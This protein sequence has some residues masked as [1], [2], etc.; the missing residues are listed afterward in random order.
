MVLA[1]AVGSFFLFLLL[2]LGALAVTAALDKTIGKEKAL[3][4][5][6]AAIAA[7]VFFTGPTADTAGAGKSAS[8][9]DVEAPEVV[10]VDPFAHPP[11]NPA[12]KRN[13]F[14]KYSDTRPLPPITLEQ[15]PWIPLAFP[16]PPTVPGPA[17]AFRR[18]LRGEVP[19]LTAG[20][21]SAIADIPDD[22]FTEYKATPKDV[23]DWVVGPAGKPVYIYIRALKTPEGKWVREGAEG[24]D[25]LKWRLY[26]QGEGW[27][28]LMV[29]F[30]YVGP[31]K[32]AAEHV[33]L[34]SQ[35]ALDAEIRLLL[36]E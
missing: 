3:L 5:Y 17:P 32:I 15:P 8:L 31:E 12:L 13:V 34:V 1:G 18:S 25:D 10:E 20:D 35:E 27:E 19:T 16:L 26:R 21:G 6:A 24:F 28:D 4:I 9:K 33:G 14:Q 7:F 30:A 11:G 23:Y 2:G 36:A 29:R 22:T